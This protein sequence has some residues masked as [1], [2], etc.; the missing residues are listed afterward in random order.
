[1]DI[2]GAILTGA[3]AG[4]WTLFGMNIAQRIYKIYKSLGKQKLKFSSG[5][6]NKGRRNVEK[7]WRSSNIEIEAFT[8]KKFIKKEATISVV[9]DK[10][11]E[12]NMEEVK[13]ES[14]DNYMEYQDCV[15][16]VEMNCEKVVVKNQEVEVDVEKDGVEHETVET[17]NFVDFLPSTASNRSPPRDE[18]LPDFDPEKFIPG[19][20]PKTVK[21]GED[22]YVIVVTGVADTGLCGKYW[23]GLTNLPSRRR[24]GAPSSEEMPTK[25]EIQKIEENEAIDV[26]K[27]DVMEIEED[28]GEKKMATIV[29]KEERSREE[30]NEYKFEHGLIDTFIDES[31]WEQALASKYLGNHHKRVEV[32]LI[33]LNIPGVSLVNGNEEV[34]LKKWKSTKK[35]SKLQALKK[36]NTTENDN[37]IKRTGS[38]RMVKKKSSRKGFFKE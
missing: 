20:V 11:Q 24:S 19:Y 31:N 12:D 16:K 30:A 21:K 17:V 35:S 27:K 26:M 38:N 28:V 29:K 14:H 2:S 18:D 15:K 23:G 5:K 36:T 13:L 3:K 9:E 6:V 4:V 7:T 33:K 37:K 25:S 32:N 8:V 34:D 22:E 1:M 10:I